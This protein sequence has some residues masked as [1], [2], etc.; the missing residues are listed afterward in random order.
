[1]PIE[2]R[3]YLPFLLGI[4][5]LLGLYSTSTYSYLLFHILVEMFAIIVAFS[6][7]A[8][9]W[10]SRRFIENHYLLF[11]GIAFLF[12]GSLE[13]LHTLAYKGMGVFQ[14][15]DANPATQLWISTKYLQSISFVIAPFFIGRKLNHNRAF[16][17]YAFISLVL[18]YSIFYLGI[19]PACYIEG[20]GLTPFKIISEYIISLIYLASLGLLYLRRGAFDKDLMRMLVVSILTAIASEVSFTQYA[21]VYG[22]SNMIGHM[23]IV[24]SFYFIYKAIVV[25]GLVKPYNLMFRDL[26]KSEEG[27]LRAN[28][29]LEE[30]VEKRTAELMTLNEQ[31]ELELSER[32]KAQ[33]ALL[34]AKEELEIKVDE[35]TLQLKAVNENLQFELEKRKAAEEAMK[36][37]LDESKLRQTEISALLEGARAVLTHHE[38]MDS[39][40]SIFDSCKNLIGA[41]AGYI[42]MISEDGANNEVLFLESGG[43]PCSVDPNLPMPIRGLRGEVYKT[44]NALYNNDFT[45]SEWIKFLPG[46]HVTIQNVLFAPLAVG[47]KIVGLLGIANK[48]GGFTDNDARIASAFGELASVAFLN[49][50]T[51]ESL[52]KTEQR[53]A[54]LIVE[55]EV[56]NRE[57]NDFAHIVS[58]DL[59]APLRAI[60]SL[61]TWIATD[62]RDMLDLKGK[63]HINLLLNRVSRMHSLIDGI[64]RYS[65]AGRIREEKTEIDLNDLIKNAADMISPLKNIKLTIEKELPT[66]VCEKTRI[67]Q[68]FQNLIGNA[69]K[70]MDKPE[71]E[72]RVGC[73]PDGDYYIFSVS[74]NGPGIEERHFDRIF[75]I[76]Q[77]LSSRDELESTGIGLALVKKIVEMYGGKVW[78]GSNMGRG[79]TFYF[80]LPKK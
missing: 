7:F 34:K 76:F 36:N 12:V 27:L 42:A 65:R 47:G 59:K 44:G 45:S 53:Q 60:S 6:I 25:T 71:G 31:L 41:T 66:I 30:R 73:A 63:E 48:P 50:R 52:E 38:F 55:L 28:D 67:E 26:K 78:V 18:L 80:T 35:R 9:A 22:F 58:H 2:T 46:G 68:V 15:Y 4:A 72:I 8:L 69:V 21:S 17:I 1:M 54:E 75:Q 70:F 14:G 62:Y 37:A 40:R 49:S 10:N 16:A 77:T 39:A 20:K 11:I 43:L 5:L 29:E 57:L 74:D 33:E 51:L 32:I 13:L 3:K 61:A 79:S 24:V 23:F 64:L 19:F 56:I